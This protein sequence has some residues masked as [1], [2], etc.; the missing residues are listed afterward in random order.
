V[1]GDHQHRPAF[2]SGTR[3][4]DQIDPNEL[5]PAASAFGTTLGDTVSCR[6]C[7]HGSLRGVPSAEELARTYAHVEDAGSLDEEAGQVAT[8]ERDLRAVRE[9]LGAP[10]GAL[11]DIGC[12]TGSLLD[13][14]RALGWETEGIEPS[15]WA[16][17]RAEQRGHTVAVGALGEVDLRREH[18]Q[19]I[20]CCDVLEHL[21]DPG[22]AVAR[23]AALLEP[24]GLLF[25]TVP[26]AGSR[27]ARVLGRRW[28]SVLPMHVQYFTRS[29]LVRL[30]TDAGLEVLSVRTHPKVFTR[31]YY[32]DRLG[33]FLPGASGAV[34]RLTSLGSWAD[35]PFA[36]DL[37]DRM[38]LIARRREGTT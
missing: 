3:S 29:S 34:A 28:W 17:S 27:L 21:V 36:P 15:D 4:L 1:C 37:R 14:A 7:G 9:L 13:A 35:R 11:L 6:S 33:E 22:D 31:R 2:R 32:A 8:A 38:A 30:L 24:G 20:A 26:D 19:V 25:A 16:A 18:Y 23:I 5:A 12:W 10:P